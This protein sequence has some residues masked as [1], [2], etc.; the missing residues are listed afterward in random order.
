MLYH[1]WLKERNACAEAVAWVGD[2][3]LQHAWTMTGHG[4][5]MLWLLQRLG[6]DDERVLRLHACWCVRQVWHLLT[7][8]RSRNVVE[9]AER[10][11]VG[12]AT[13]EELAAAGAA[14]GAA[15]ET[16]WAARDAARAAEVAARVAG[17]AAGAARAAQAD[18]LRETIPW[19]IVSALAT[20]AGITE[21]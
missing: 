2:Q 3:S 21:E 1:E 8:E 4:D 12:E 5:W 20:K 16:A 13:R 17:V 15:A 18:H 14:A 9:V 10:F 19:E 7:D 11:A 6:Y